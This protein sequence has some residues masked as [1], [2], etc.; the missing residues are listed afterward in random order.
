MPVNIQGMQH[1]PVLPTD[2]C[3]QR[4]EIVGLGRSDPVIERLHD[5]F[6]VIMP[7]RHQK[8]RKHAVQASALRIITLV[9]RDK[10]PFRVPAF[11][12]DDTPAVI[13]EVQN[14]FFTRWTKEFTAVR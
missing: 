6:F 9:T 12:P 13:P 2:H 3:F 8:I 10:D 11:I 1:Q 14:T 4:R 5:H 7:E